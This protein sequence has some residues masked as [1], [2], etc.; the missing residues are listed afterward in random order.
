PLGASTLNQGTINQSAF[1]LTGSSLGSTIP[2]STDLTGGSSGMSS[3]GSVGFG[4]SSLGTTGTPGSPFTGQPN[5]ALQGTIGTYPGLN[6][7]QGLGTNTGNLFYQYYAN[8]LYQGWPGNYPRNPGGWGVPLS[9]VSTFG[10]VGSAGSSVGGISGLGG[11][12]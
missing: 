4:L 10:T 6:Q 8:P 7:G 11:S 3:L 2:A 9:Q 5:P 1:G 12:L